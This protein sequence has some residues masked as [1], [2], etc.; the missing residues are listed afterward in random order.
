M[1]LTHPDRD[2]WKVEPTFQ[3]ALS[4]RFSRVCVPDFG[5]KPLKSASK[6]AFGEGCSTTF[7]N[8][9]FGRIN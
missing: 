1:H 2:F 9:G 4:K 7:Q 5:Y 8:L 6:K 3:H